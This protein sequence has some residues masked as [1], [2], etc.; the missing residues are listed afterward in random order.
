MVL[1]PNFIFKSST[2]VVGLR[3]VVIFLWDSG[4]RDSDFATR[5]IRITRCTIPKKNNDCSHFTLGV[6]ELNLLSDDFVFTVQLGSIPGLPAKSCKEIKN[7]EGGQAESKKYWFYSIIPGTT[8]L[9]PCDM[10]TDGMLTNLQPNLYKRSPFRGTQQTVSVNIGG[11]NCKGGGMVRALVSHRCGLDSIPGPDVICALSL[12]L[13][14]SLL[15]EVFLRVL[16]FFPLVK[17]QHF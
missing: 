15:Q 7:N 14:L 17:T 6:I 11:S 5:V 3:A 16:R 2:L 4:T 12:L 1:E 10:R 9:A 8:V 13:V